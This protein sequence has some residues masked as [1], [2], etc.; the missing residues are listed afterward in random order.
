ML[1]EFLLRENNCLS[2]D[3]LSQKTTPALAK[4]NLYSCKVGDNLERGGWPLSSCHDFALVFLCSAPHATK[5]TEFSVAPQVP[6]TGNVH[7]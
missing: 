4:T 7:G 5:V 3:C 1:H 6:D 2:H